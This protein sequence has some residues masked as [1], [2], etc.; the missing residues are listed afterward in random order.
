MN[1]KIT[2]II[3]LGLMSLVSLTNAE[4]NNANEAKQS[5]KTVAAT[6]KIRKHTISNGGGV[7]T[8]S[9]GDFRITSSIGQIDA[10][11]NTNTSGISYIFHGGFLTS[12]NSQSE[13]IFKNGFE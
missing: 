9:N 6:Y 5:D 4:T 2:T 1:I 13:S 12:P 11:H 10:G 7:I 8:S 3:I